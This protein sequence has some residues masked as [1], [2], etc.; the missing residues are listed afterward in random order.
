VLRKIIGVYY[1]SHMKPINY[2]SRQNTALLMTIKA[3]QGLQI[4]TTKSSLFFP[5]TS[6]INCMANVNRK[7]TTS[8]KLFYITDITRDRRVEGE[9]GIYA[10]TV[11]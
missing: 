8:G 11:Y 4:K 1:G 7:I 10:V 6:V 5:Y 2:M 3:G 9:H